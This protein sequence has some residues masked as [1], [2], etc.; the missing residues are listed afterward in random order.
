MRRWDRILDSYIE[1]YAARGISKEFGGDELGS[2]RAMGT[3]TQGSAAEGEHRA[4]RRGLDH[5]LHRE[6]LDLQSQGDRV[7]NVEHDARIRGLSGAPRAVT[8]NSLRW[9]KGPKV[10]PYSRLPKRIDREH[11]APAGTSTSSTRGLGKLPHLAMAGRAMITRFDAP[12]QD[13]QRIL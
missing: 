2:P 13:A 9:M 3:M 8:I 6:L 10:T 5:P 12:W 4:H 1:E 7:R 11:M